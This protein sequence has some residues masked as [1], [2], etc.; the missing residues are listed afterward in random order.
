MTLFSMI[1]DG[2]DASLLTNIT[3][4]IS[5]MCARDFEGIELDPTRDICAHSQGVP[6]A[7]SSLTGSSAATTFADDIVLKFRDCAQRLKRTVLS[8]LRT[9]TSSIQHFDA[10]RT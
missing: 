2:L 8:L 10:L 4:S 1:L 7:P 6:L 5:G 9:V 3:S